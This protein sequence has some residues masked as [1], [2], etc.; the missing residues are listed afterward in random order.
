MTPTQFDIRVPK[1]KFVAEYRGQIIHIMV[2]N[3]CY[4]D[5]IL[6]KHYCGQ[7]FERR[8]EFIH[9]ILS[10]SFDLMRKKELLIIMLENKYPK[11]LEKH[12]A[13]KKEIGFKKFFTNLIEL[14][15]ICAHRR[16]ITDDSTMYD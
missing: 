12:K 14:R 9:T 11:F 13:T 2:Q 16:Y 6:A 5:D 15:N 10:K 1:E 4:I 3:E 7:N 8:K